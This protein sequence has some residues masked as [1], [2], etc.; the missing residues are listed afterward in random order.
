MKIKRFN[1][2]GGDL[3]ARVGNFANTEEYING[4][5]DKLKNDISNIFE[6][7]SVK[8]YHGREQEFIFDKIVMGPNKYDNKGKKEKFTIVGIDDERSEFFCYLNEIIELVDL[9][10]IA[11]THPQEFMKIL[12]FLDSEKLLRKMEERYPQYKKYYD[13]RKYNL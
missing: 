8:F 4:L 2:G 1:E 3:N 10:D 12:D 13:A 7:K 5:F 9:N 11:E 6:N